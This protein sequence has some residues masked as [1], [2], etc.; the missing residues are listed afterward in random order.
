VS[1]AREPKI[2][3]RP[4]AGEQAQFERVDEPD[5]V[6]QLRERRACCHG[7]APHG[8][9]RRASPGCSRT[10]VLIQPRAEPIR[11]DFPAD[12]ET[13]RSLQGRLYQ[14]ADLHQALMLLW[15]RHAV[16]RR[17]GTKRGLQ[18]GNRRLLRTWHPSTKPTRSK[19]GGSLHPSTKPTCSKL[20][21]S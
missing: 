8:S 17:S 10:Y 12:A 9:A 1:H 19:L 14:L 13:R 20:G 7:R 2:T 21:G 16:E 5:V 15:Q 6:K 4:V 3:P 11:R 18:L